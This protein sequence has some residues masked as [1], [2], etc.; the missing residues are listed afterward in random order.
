M[1]ANRKLILFLQVGEVHAMSQGDMYFTS[2]KKWGEQG[3][4]NREGPENAR[5]EKQ[6]KSCTTVSSGREWCVAV[7]SDIRVKMLHM[8][9]IFPKMGELA[10]VKVSGI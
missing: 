1:S 3:E 8:E 7:L 4:F 10:E 9:Q 6:S 5:R 2:K